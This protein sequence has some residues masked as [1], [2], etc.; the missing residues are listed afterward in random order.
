[1]DGPSTRGGASRPRASSWQ[2]R[3]CWPPRAWPQPASR[4]SPPRTPATPSDRPRRRPRRRRRP[5]PRRPLK[6][7][8]A[9][10][11]ALARSTPVPGW[12]HDDAQ[13][14][15]FR[16]PESL[17]IVRD[18]FE[19]VITRRQAR[20]IRRAPRAGRHRHV[21]AF[22]RQRHPASAS[23]RKERAERRVEIQSGVAGEIFPH[24]L[25]MI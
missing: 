19:R 17:A 11:M 6:L 7:P 16:V 9:A 14:C 10:W 3:P 15:A 13:G 8:F 18:H 21:A 20:K 25:S 4:P 24:E 22:A 12:Q 5:A 2:L 23:L 1:M